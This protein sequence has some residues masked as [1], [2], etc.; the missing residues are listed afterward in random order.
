[1]E[2]LRLNAIEQ[3]RANATE[4]AGVDQKTAEAL[5]QDDSFS[6]DDEN[7]EEVGLDEKQDEKT[8]LMT[9]GIV[10]G[11][12]DEEEG[13]VGEL[14]TDHVEFVEYVEG[15]SKATGPKNDYV[16]NY[17][18]DRGYVDCELEQVEQPE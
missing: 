2:E 15:G 17:M 18:V 12:E 6:D 5:S 13:E 3:A 8:P 7:D 1:V 4:S 14:D 10:S 16:P 9:E 11:D